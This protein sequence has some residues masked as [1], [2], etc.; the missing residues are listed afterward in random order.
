M[1]IDTQSP[2]I[3][4]LGG[5]AL[6]GEPP[7][8]SPQH[9]QAVITRTAKQLA[10]HIEA[11]QSIVLT[12]GNGPQIGTRLLQQEHSPETP[13]FGLDILV[14]ETQAQIGYQLQQALEN[15]TGEQT[16]IPTVLT[17]V[18]VDQ[19]DPAFEKPTKP[20]GP[21]YT[22]TEAA[23]QPFE[24]RMIAEDPPT[25]R[26]VVASPIP[27]A[28]IEAETIAQIIEKN[29]GLVCAG[30][31]GIP[32]HHEQ[33]SHGVPAVVDKDQTSQ[34]LGTQLESSTLVFLTDVNY[35]YTG[36]GT[37]TQQPLQTV[38]PTTVREHMAADEFGTGSMQPKMEA[39]IGFLDAGGKR[40]VITTPGQ[41][42][43]ALAGETGTQIRAPEAH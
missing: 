15:A 7:D 3:V 36:Y 16:T 35:A 34:V 11:D 10:P 25:Y 8:Q 30:G 18:L 33:G 4:A 1:S 37:A 13:Q 29:E 24:T 14:A 27:Q 39:A 12:H 31:G 19:S 22:A 41:F 32:V 17:R 23:E 20:I 38:S 42:A 21:K 43:E 5:N 40:A 28:I 9:Q 2:L 6:L 26:R